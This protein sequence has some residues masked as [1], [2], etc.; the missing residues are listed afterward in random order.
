MQI[1]P[2]NAAYMYEWNVVHL[3][4][5][6]SQGSAATEYRRDGR[7]YFTVFHSLSTNPKVKELLKS[8][9]ICQSYSKN[10]SGPVFL[11]SQYICDFLLVINS[12]FG[13]ILHHFWHMATYWL[14]IAYFSYLSLIRHPT[15]YVPFGV[16]RQELEPRVM[17][18][19]CSEGCMIQTSTVFDW[20]TCV[21]DGQ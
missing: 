11:N 13:P 10:K 5:Y 15:A 20:S 16:S 21:T 7:F 8:V 3:S 18:L 9:H 19:L 4:I 12:N 17:R 6:I 2:A 1:S 14:T